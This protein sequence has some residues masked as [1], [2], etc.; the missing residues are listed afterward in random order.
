MA[1]DPRAEADA[2]YRAAQRFVDVALASDDSLF[3][4]GRPIWSAG[5]A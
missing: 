3:T 1:R 5:T 4:P 2:V